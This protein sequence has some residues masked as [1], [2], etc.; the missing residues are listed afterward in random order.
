MRSA[1]LVAL[2]IF[3]L[4]SSAAP[5]QAPGVVEVHLSN[6]K[7]T[8]SQVQFQHGQAYVLRLV[9][10]GGGGHDFTA[11]AFFAGAAVAPGDRRWISDGEIEVPGHQVREIHLTAPRPGSYKL[12]CTH[13]LHSAFGMKGKIVVR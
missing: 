5:A 6:F 2:P 7:F 11:P 8:P 12:K 9:N 1:L 10:D 3:V 4:A 13:S